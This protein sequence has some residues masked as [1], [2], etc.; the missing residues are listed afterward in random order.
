MRLSRVS[1][2]FL[3]FLTSVTSRWTILDLRRNLS[4]TTVYPSGETAH[5]RVAAVLFLRLFETM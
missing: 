3:P 1:F 4:L 2:P 5:L